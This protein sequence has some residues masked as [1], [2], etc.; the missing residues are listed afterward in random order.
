[1]CLLYSPKLRFFV[2][3][4]CS[5]T[6]KGLLFDTDFSVKLNLGHCPIT[7]LTFFVTIQHHG[8]LTPGAKFCRLF[9]PEPLL[10]PLE[11]GRFAYKI[12]HQRHP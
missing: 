4:G 10:I 11:R 6:P 9:L 3:L 2:G 7:L 8:D 12:S 1:M 5:L